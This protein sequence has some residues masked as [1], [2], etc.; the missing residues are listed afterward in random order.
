MFLLLDEMIFQNNRIENDHIT[1][2][3]K[4]KLNLF[5]ALPFKDI[6]KHLMKQRMIKSDEEIL[7]IKNGAQ[8]QLVEEIVKHIKHANRIRDCHCRTR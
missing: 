4:E 8:L 2:D 3:I 6:S 7:I 5:L 1:L